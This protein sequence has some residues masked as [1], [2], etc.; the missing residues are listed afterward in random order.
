M[1]FLRANHP[2][3]QNLEID[4]DNL[5]ALPE[6][7]PVTDQ[8]P[9]RKVD[10]P[11]LPNFNDSL[12]GQ[13]TNTDLN[14]PDDE[15]RPPQTAVVPNLLPDQTE[16]ECLQRVLTQATHPVGSNVLSMA[17][18]ADD[19]VSEWDSKPVFRMAFPGLFPYRRGDF[20]EQRGEVISLS[21]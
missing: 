10:E 3:Y 19:P 18:V 8:L 1:V 6:D 20:Y 21:D 15:I 2:D 7:G 14:E 12:A 9:T 5:L 4:G 13:D 16:M 17:S 11:L